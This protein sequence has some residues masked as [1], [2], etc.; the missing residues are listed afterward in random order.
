MSGILHTAEREAIRQRLVKIFRRGLGESRIVKSVDGVR[1]LNFSPHTQC[2]IE[3]E[4]GITLTDDDF[5]DA[6]R[7]SDLVLLVE[8]KMAERAAK[9]TQDREGW[10]A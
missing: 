3:A 6:V 4:F 9:L 2:E 8:Q 5:A 10:M 7:F 1:S